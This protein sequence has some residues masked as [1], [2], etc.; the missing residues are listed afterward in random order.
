MKPTV[1]PSAKPTVAP[2]R[3]P[4]DVPVTASPSNSPTVTPSVSPTVSTTENG[5]NDGYELCVEQS[6]AG[7]VDLEIYRDADN[8]MM[9]IKISGPTDSWFGFGFGST[10]MSG[11]YSVIG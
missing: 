2:S 5:D 11:T 9:K 1:S 6:G 10:S 4:T 7:D 8:E 3:S